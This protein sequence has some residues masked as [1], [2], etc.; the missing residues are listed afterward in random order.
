MMQSVKYTPQMGPLGK[1]KYTEMRQKTYLKWYACFF[2]N[3][4]DRKLQA[5]DSEANPSK[6]FPKHLAKNP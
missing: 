4:L 2:I 1:C 3:Y 6:E 5:A